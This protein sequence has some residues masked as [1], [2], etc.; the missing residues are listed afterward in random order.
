MHATNTVT[1]ADVLRLLPLQKGHFRFE[2]GHHSDTWIDLQTLC[3]RPE[4]VETLAATLSERI[5]KY[6]I[7]AVCGPL[8]EGAFVALM[9]ASRL[10]VL[11]TYA[12][13]FERPSDELYPVQYR[14]PR[15]LRPIVRGKRTAIIND[16][17]SA[18][19]AVRGTLADLLECG[20][21]PVVVGTLAVLGDTFV[22]QNKLPLETLVSLPNEIWKPAECPLCARGVAL[23]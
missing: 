10:R 19:S 17:T 22:K 23:R 9:V 21:N 20:A 6:D 7:E 11:F 18:G 16:V 13:R 4:A 2:S 8:V 15:T 12:E 1:G 3:L 14:V 5:A